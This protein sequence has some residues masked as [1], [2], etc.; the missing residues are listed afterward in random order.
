MKGNPQIV[1]ERLM[2]VRQAR[3]SLTPYD[4]VQE[5]RRHSSP[6]HPYF[7]WDDQKAAEEYRKRQ[8]GHL[9]RCVV[10][11]EHENYE[12]TRPIRA[13]VNIAE[14]DTEN[15]YESVIDVLS[16]DRMREQVLAH[17]QQ[18]LDEHKEKLEIFE[19]LVDV[20]SGIELVQK[21]VK[22]HRKHSGQESRVS[23]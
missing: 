10:L 22:K 1:G 19:E 3:G 12:L 20:V 7:E 8:A 9:I 15:S 13:F 6:L 14:S 17:L 11:A 2:Q 5:A 18:S 23:G 16:D 4:V 21:S